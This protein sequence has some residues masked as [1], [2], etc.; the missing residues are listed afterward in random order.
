MYKR[1]IRLGTRQS[2]EICLQTGKEENL[3]AVQFTRLDA[4][5][6]PIWPQKPGRYLDGVLVLGPP[7]KAKMLRTGTGRCALSLSYAQTIRSGSCCPI[8]V[9]CS[10]D[11][12]D[13][14]NQVS[15]LG[16]L[17]PVN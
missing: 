4:L 8:G 16:T 12:M 10:G 11:V 5:V 7:W 13:M 14:P 2:K 6:G 17:N 1:I 15:F 3:V 9:T